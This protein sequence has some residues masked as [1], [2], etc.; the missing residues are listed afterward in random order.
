ML[1]LIIKALVIIFTS[2]ECSVMVVLMSP[3]SLAC[4]SAS[5]WRNTKILG[6]L[7]ECY[8]LCRFCYCD[9]VT[10]CG[11]Q[12][13]A[14]TLWWQ[15]AG[16]NFE[17][18]AALG[19]SVLLLGPIF[20]FPKQHPSHWRSPPAPPRSSLLSVCALCATG[21]VFTGHCS[22]KVAGAHARVQWALDTAGRPCSSARVRGWL[23]T[24]VQGYARV[25]GAAAPCSLWT[26]AP[27][28]GTAALVLQPGVAGTATNITV[29]A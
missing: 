17:G 23:V 15:G 21:V 27:C 3:L 6:I 14:H 12:H 7:A 9:I 16:R 18:W 22:W 1:R 29:Q 28:D 4:C 11:H 25:G 10:A 24:E 26:V 5:W 2:S 19:C 8:S 20:T 13:G